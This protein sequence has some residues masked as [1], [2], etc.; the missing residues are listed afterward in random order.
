MLGSPPP[1]YGDSTISQPNRGQRSL[2]DKAQTHTIL[3]FFSGHRKTWTLLQERYIY[4]Y[5][6]RSFRC[7][8]VTHLHHR[9]VPGWEREIYIGKHILTF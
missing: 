7:T 3:S 6:T 2:Y 8:W 9:H 5:I 4:I 1:G